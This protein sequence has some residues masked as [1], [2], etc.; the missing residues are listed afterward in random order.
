MINRLLLVFLLALSNTV[1][2]EVQCASMLVA[3]IKIEGDEVYSQFIDQT[4]KKIDQDYYIT[5][6][7]DVIGSA[8]FTLL[9]S[10][11]M[12]VSP[13]SLVYPNGFDCNSPNP[14]I[15]AKKVISGV[16]R[17]L[18][19][20]ASNE[21]ILR[22]VGNNDSYTFDWQLKAG[23]Q[24]DLRFLRHHDN[25]ICNRGRIYLNSRLPAERDYF[26]RYFQF[27]V[28]QNISDFEKNTGYH[29]QIEAEF[30]WFDYDD[31]FRGL[32]KQTNI[33]LMNSG[34]KMLDLV[35]EVRCLLF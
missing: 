20:S 2:S 4:G 9:I 21:I 7:N 12:T 34:D 6:Y 24:V 15:K 3:A 14:E 16:E 30:R 33:T 25:R 26:E 10:S 8:V 18:R 11:K 13:I 31:S 17:D 28:P 22:R 29:R 1:Y 23:E 32:D 35:V 19:L 5:D 27:I